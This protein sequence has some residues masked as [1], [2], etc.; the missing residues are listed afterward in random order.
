MEPSRAL[1]AGPSTA[2]GITRSPVDPDPNNDAFAVGSPNPASH[3]INFDI[4]V[5]CRGTALLRASRNIPEK[6]LCGNSEGSKEFT[7]DFRRPPL[8]RRTRFFHS[9]ATLFA[10]SIFDPADRSGG[11][12]PSRCRA[13]A[14]RA[15]GLAARDRRFLASGPGDV[16]GY[17]RHRRA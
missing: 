10:I 6:P 4:P 16:I 1:G 5:R 7:Q 11:A 8:A 2:N 13:G 9:L 14:E 12:C 17:G 15:G 3:R